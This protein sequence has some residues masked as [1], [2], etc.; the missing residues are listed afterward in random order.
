MSEQS[1][2]N[3]QDL[4]ND[5]DFL[6]QLETL[7]LDTDD[8]DLTKA[9]SLKSSP[10]SDMPNQP[11]THANLLDEL[12]LGNPSLS[13]SS[14]SNLGFDDGFDDNVA[15]TA[16]P[17]KKSFFGKKSA[18]KLTKIPKQ[19]DQ[20]AS[21]A[22]NL[23]FIIIGAVVSLL[24]LVGAYLLASGDDS[25]PT[26][27]VQVTS[28]PSTTAPADTTETLSVTDNLDSDTSADSV[29]IDNAPADN[30][31]D[32]TAPADT[33]PIDM[34]IVNA[35]E[36]VNASIPDDHA[37]IKEEIDRLKD[38]DAQLAEQAQL[39]DE[40][41]ATLAQLTDAKEEQIRLLEAQIAHLESQKGN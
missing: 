9:D 21:K 25:T 8:I 22:I 13:K 5:D 41:L 24:L 17:T 40:Q 15:Q 18:S 39:I 14:Q 34:P 2:K 27:A 16:L 7:N 29:A 23:N 30:T 20:T 4:P 38:K 33:M 28:E 36:I 12:D 3:P 37:L 1:Y 19:A 10:A 11:Q 32:D 35:D 26:T 6:K 31:P